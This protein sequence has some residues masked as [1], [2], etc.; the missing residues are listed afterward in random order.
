[1]PLGS[2]AHPPKTSQKQK[3][4]RADVAPDAAASTLLRD[5]ERHPGS[6]PASSPRAR[7]PP[8]V[9]GSPLVPTLGDRRGGPRLSRLPRGCAP[10]FPG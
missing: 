6:S 9:R 5:C 8:R 7:P 3:Q 10:H 4:Q 1:M 2:G